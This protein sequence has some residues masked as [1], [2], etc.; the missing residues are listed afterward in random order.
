[1]ASGL[2]LIASDNRGTRDFLTNKNALACPCHD[3]HSFANAIRLLAGD[4]ELRA[5]MGRENLVLS[6]QFNVAVI[7][8][9][10][11]KLYREAQT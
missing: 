5:G 3:V 1:M 10:M 7:N 9:T 8:E 11:Q 6:K 2:P 4:A